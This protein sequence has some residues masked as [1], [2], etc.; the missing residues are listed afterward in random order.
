MDQVHLSRFEAEI[1]NSLTFLDVIEVIKKMVDVLFNHINA[2]TKD[3]YECSHYDQHQNEANTLKAV[4][5]LEREVK[6]QIKVNREQE[7]E[8][9]SIEKDTKKLKEE[10]DQ[11][12]EQMLVYFL[13]T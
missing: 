1:T 13:L 12:K 11:S 4:E 5:R 3:L 2:L 9:I 10:L 6:V 8:M 7:K